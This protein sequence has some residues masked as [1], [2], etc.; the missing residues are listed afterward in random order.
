MSNTNK[1]TITRRK[2]TFLILPN[3]YYLDISKTITDGVYLCLLLDEEDGYLEPSFCFMYGKKKRNLSRQK[4][5]LKY[6]REIAEAL[7]EFYQLN[8]EIMRK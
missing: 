6:S 2:T 5:L 8:E 3:Y 4:I 7:Y 1:L